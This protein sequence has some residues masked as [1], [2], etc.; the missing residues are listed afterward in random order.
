[1]LAVDGASGGD[2]LLPLDPRGTERLPPPGAERGALAPLLAAKVGRLGAEIAVGVAL[3]ALLAQLAP[4]GALLLPQ[5]QPFPTLA[6]T[7]VLDR[8]D[9]ERENADGDDQ[10]HLPGNVRGREEQS[11]FRLAFGLGQNAQRDLRTGADAVRLFELAAAGKAHRDRTL[12]FTDIR[13]I[14]FEHDV[15]RIA[16]VDRA[17][18]G[19]NA[20][21]HV[22]VVD[23]VP[24][25]GGIF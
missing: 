9:I 16:R 6:Q 19:E 15:D 4:L 10:L 8:I 23:V 5:R 24:G 20:V 17:I 2:P 7:D 14:A 18:E 11:R 12:D 13:E 25:T 22:D 3:P 21:L 1:M